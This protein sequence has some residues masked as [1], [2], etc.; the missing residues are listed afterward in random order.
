M[1]VSATEWK[2]QASTENYTQA[3]MAFLAAV[4]APGEMPVALVSKA[5]FTG[6]LNDA[7]RHS[8]KEDQEIAS[9]MHISAGYMSRFM[10]SVGEHWAKRLL[11]F[12]RSTNSLAPLQWLADQM[13][14]DLVRRDS[15]AAEVAALKQRLNELEKAA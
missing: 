1:T 15:R 5:S 2:V 10:R 8:G 11:R 12:M 9:D 6:C 3:E 4:Q 13:G 14:C 7:A